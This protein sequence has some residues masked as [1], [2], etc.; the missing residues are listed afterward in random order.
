MTKIKRICVEL[1]FFLVRHQW[2]KKHK[3]RNYGT[4]WNATQNYVIYTRHLWYQYV[5]V[6]VCVCVCVCAC[7]FI[8]VLH[9]QCVH[10]IA[11]DIK[12]K[13]PTLKS[14]KLRFNLRWVEMH[15][16]CLCV[17]LHSF[18]EIANLSRWR[19]RYWSH[20][21]FKAVSKQMS[22]IKAAA[23]ISADKIGR[24]LEQMMP[25]LS[26]FGYMLWFIT[27][28]CRMHIHWVHNFRV[29]SLSLS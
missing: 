19:V 26:L 11:L 24:F 29:L 6:C 14:V 5:D 28:G 1:T 23:W 15:N 7:V 12:S 22:Q 18:H 10:M 25:I 13:L 21:K 27:P 17:W 8:Y 16:V 4:R 20:L 3:K 2:Y 9:T